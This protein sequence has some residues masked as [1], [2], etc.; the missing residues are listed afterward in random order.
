MPAFD[1]Y[2]IRFFAPSGE[3]V[4][5]LGVPLLDDYLDFVAARSRAEHG[6]GHRL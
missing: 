3:P 1:P 4:V 6:A 5:R 2:L